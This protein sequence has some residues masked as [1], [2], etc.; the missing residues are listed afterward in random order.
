MEDS[1]YNESSGESKQT[2]KST[3]KSRPPIKSTLPPNA[4][5]R[6]DQADPPEEKK[7]ASWSRRALARTKDIL[8]LSAEDPSTRAFEQF[9]EREFKLHGVKPGDDAAAKLHVSSQKL[10]P[11]APGRR[12]KTPRHTRKPSTAH[13]TRALSTGTSSTGAGSITSSNSGNSSNLGLMSSLSIPGRTD[14]GSSAS[15]GLPES[16]TFQSS[17][18]QANE[19]GGPSSGQVSRMDKTPKYKLA[20]N[21]GFDDRW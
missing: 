8:S 2:L 7:K 17:R 10:P 6:K 9:R 19:V 4:F 11:E 18:S 15:P 12:S 21:N 3:P 1:S 14:S 16:R 20:G 13:L 5:S